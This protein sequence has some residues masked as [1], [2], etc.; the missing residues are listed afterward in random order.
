MVQQEGGA[1]SWFSKEQVRALDAYAQHVAD[2]MKKFPLHSE[3]AYLGR[4][5][6]VMGYAGSGWNAAL[7]LRYADNN[8]VIREVQLSYLEAMRL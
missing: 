6:K 2:L 7:N 1:V 5:C 4:T 3:C 8:G